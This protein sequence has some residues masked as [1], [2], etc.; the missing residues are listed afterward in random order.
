MCRLPA[1]QLTHRHACTHTRTRTPAITQSYFKLFFAKDSQSLKPPLPKLLPLTSF[2]LRLH[3]SVQKT[4]WFPIGRFFGSLRCG[5][6]RWVGMDSQV[7]GFVLVF[8][9]QNSTHGARLLES[10]QVKL[11]KQGSSKHFCHQWCRCRLGQAVTQK[12]ATLFWSI[13]VMPLLHLN[14]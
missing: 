8:E 9:K 4:G 10:L 11:I 1:P 5:S 13:N 6:R 14:D 12:Y 2:P 3:P 7:G